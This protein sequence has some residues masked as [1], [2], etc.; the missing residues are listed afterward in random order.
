MVASNDTRGS[1]PSDSTVGIWIVCWL[2]CRWRWR[3][4]INMC[5]RKAKWRCRLCMIGCE[6]N[7][8]PAIALRKHERAGLSDGRQPQMRDRSHTAQEECRELRQE[9]VE[10]ARNPA[11]LLGCRAQGR[12]SFASRYNTVVP[13][14]PGTDSYLAF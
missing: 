1:A 4:D 14:R 6:S 5:R 11:A 3:T 7:M 9:W 10:P 8:T 12:E 13:P 2:H